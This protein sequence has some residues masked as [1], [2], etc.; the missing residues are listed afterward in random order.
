MTIRVMVVDDSPLV[1]KIATDILNSQP[2]IEV[3]VT[4]ATAEFALHKLERQR[5]DVITMDMEMPGMG[6]LEGI[7]QIMARRP[8][9]VIVLSAHAKKGAELTLQALEA[10]AVEFVL[11]PTASLSGG[12]DTVAMELV[13]KVKTASGVT[14]K[15]VRTQTEGSSAAGTSRR[16]TWAGSR[17][18]LRTGRAGYEVVC[19][20][21][22]TGGPVALRALLSDLPEDFPIP[23]VVVQHM[24]SVFTTAF[25]ERLDSC[26]ALRVKEA[27]EG[28]G[29]LPGRVLIAPGDYHITVHR[30][31]GAPTVRLN[32][33]EPVSG[34][35]PSVDVLMHSAARE[36]GHRTIGVIMTGMGKDGAAGIQEL[37]QEGGYIIAQDR[38]SS[39]IF[40]MN[41]EVIRNGHAHM[42]VGLEQMADILVERT[43]VYPPSLVKVRSGNGA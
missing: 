17:D 31:D 20:G 23:I 22:S 42:I 27:E 7:R 38:D 14:A 15:P 8:T 5:P 2:G 30:L 24:P 21:T 39:V 6:G 13:D 9:P 10:G 32:Q 11:K 36:F 3:A 34:H 40:G 19:I 1:R 43:G 29:L 25:A 28:D 18:M 16:Q 37:H 35:R 26:C 4:A 41:Q 12:L 33:R